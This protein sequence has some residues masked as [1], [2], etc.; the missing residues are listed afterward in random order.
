MLIVCFC[1][2]LQFDLK[3]LYSITDAT[4]LLVNVVL[5]MT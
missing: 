5:R 4:L 3:V 2:N 1:K